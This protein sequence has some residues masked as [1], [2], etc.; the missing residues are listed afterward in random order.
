MSALFAVLAT[1]AHDAAK[2][3]RASEPEV[4]RDRKRPERETLAAREPSRRRRAT[5]R[6]ARS[7][8]AR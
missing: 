4:V 7:A 3:A 5:R 2:A 1:R 8:P 6:F